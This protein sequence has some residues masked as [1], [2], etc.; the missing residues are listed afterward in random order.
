MANELPFGS[1]ETMG[2]KSG[3]E[4]MSIRISGNVLA[5]LCVE[6][7]EAAMSVVDGLWTM[8]SSVSDTGE[9]VEVCS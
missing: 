3:V 8:L 7:Y 4:S 2:A 9:L 5:R 6:L 1:H